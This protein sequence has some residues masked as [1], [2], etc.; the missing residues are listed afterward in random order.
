MKTPVIPERRNG[1]YYVN[2]EGKDYVLPS[3]TTITSETMP[4]GNL[5]YWAAKTAARAALHN[6]TLSEDEAA[7]SITQAKTDGG[8]RGRIVHD[9]VEAMDNGATPNFDGL[10]EKI[11][12]YV[13]AFI[14]FKKDLEP[15]LVMNER[16]VMNLSL[17][18]AG[19]LDRVYEIKGQNV[20]VDFKTSKDYYPEMG[21]QLTAYKNAE[22]SF[23]KVGGPYIPMIKIDSTAIVLLGEDGTYSFK[24]TDEPLD[25]FMALRSI[26][27]WMNSAKMLAISKKV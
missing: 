9:F 13:Q 16:K 17:G 27:V 20:L 22:F 4:K 5:I 21:L 6:P 14:S 2:M 1:F 19:R 24:K 25:V 26:W 10:P 12:P 11:K 18:Y 15:K 3:V 8:D 7:K 23:E